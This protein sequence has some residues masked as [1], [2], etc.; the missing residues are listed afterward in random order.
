MSPPKP[1]PVAPVLSLTTPTTQ[2]FP[3][4]LNGGPRFSPA[5]FYP[6]TAGRPQ[7]RHRHSGSVLHSI[8]QQE[9]S[10]PD[11]FETAFTIIRSIG[12]GVSSEAFAVSSRETGA[13]SAVKRTKTPS[14]GPKDR[15][16]RL[17]EI[18]ILR[19]I[20]TGEDKSPYIV[21]LFSAW[22]QEGHLYIQ[23]ELCA[24]G[25]MAEF[26]DSHGQV[27]EFLDE[28][29]VW[30]I[31]TQIALG[32]QHLHE[33][34][35]LHLD[36]STSYVSMANNAKLLLSSNQPTS[37]SQKMAISSLVTLAWLRVGQERPL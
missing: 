28:A 23:T 22:E 2:T 27:N 33:R 20:S 4:T 17:E 31:T 11:R 24:C 5:H 13:V 26:L 12:R 6:P 10:L 37:L 7:F 35:I 29:R 36:V 34:N 32:I 8:R 19:Q 9:L 18:D 1:V 25:N 30:K 3:T 15:L 16:R 21:S 14:S